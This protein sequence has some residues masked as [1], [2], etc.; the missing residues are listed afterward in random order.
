MKN[1]ITRRRLLLSSLAGMAVPSVLKA[2]E[3]VGQEIPWLSEIQTAPSVLPGDA[4][5]LSPLLTGG[6]LA[7]WRARREEIRQWW[8]GFLGDLGPRQSMP[9][10]EVLEEDRPSGVIRQLIRYEVEP[11]LLEKAY[12][13][14]PA[15]PGGRRPGVVALHSTFA[16]NIRQ[17]AGIEGQP[18]KAFGLKLAERGCVAIC[19][20][21]FLWSDDPKVSYQ[22]HA[23]RLQERHPGV[24]GMAKMLHDAQ[25]ALDILAGLP[26]VDQNRLGAVGHSL[27]AKEAFYLAAFDERVRVTAS[28]EGGIGIGFSNWEALWYLGAD[29]RRGDFSREHHELFALVAPRA[30]L[31]LGGDSADGDRSWPFIEAV[32]PVYRLYGRTPAIG[33][34]NHKQGHAVP[35]EAERR[36]YQWLQAHL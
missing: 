28:S 25:V 22:R 8:R 34:F 4:P 29:I 6:S 5:R 14:K 27:G 9:T 33:L 21:C 7:D 26:E 17:P 16:G 32:L 31:L 3:P 11:G 35:P 15:A 10:Y 30:F 13:L 23:E 2:A 12:L 18:E 20:R 1:Q 24:K 36:I 19:P